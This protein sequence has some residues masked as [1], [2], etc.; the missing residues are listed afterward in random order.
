MKFIL[1]FLL[2][3]IFIELISRY[4]EYRESHLLYKN[5]WSYLTHNTDISVHNEKDL[6]KNSQHKHTDAFEGLV[7]DDFDFSNSKFTDVSFKGSSL[8]RANFN[9][10]E[11]QHCDFRKAD[12]QDATFINTYIKPRGLIL[13]LYTRVIE[14]IW[15]IISLAIVIYIFI[16]SF[17]TS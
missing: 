3:V 17:F 5:F 1:I 8:K 13:R 11:L 2:G 6:F 14:F 4:L 16:A 9:N 15:V 12:L 10:C 7:L